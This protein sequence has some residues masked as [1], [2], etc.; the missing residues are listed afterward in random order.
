MT[1]NCSLSSFGTSAGMGYG[2]TLPN[3]LADFQLSSW[4][5][6][7]AM[8][9]YDWKH[10]PNLFIL[11]VLWNVTM[12]CVSLLVWVW[13]QYFFFGLMC[14]SL[15]RDCGVLWY[16]YAIQSS[17]HWRDNSTC[18]YNGYDISK[19]NRSLKCTRLLLYPISKLQKLTLQMGLHC[20]GKSKCGPLCGPKS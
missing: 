13:Q 17:G 2:T 19:G 3:R 6:Y 14:A 10:K 4:C 1:C 7:A 11:P 18:H 9:E 15:A 20:I 12:A 5:W 8:R 16:A